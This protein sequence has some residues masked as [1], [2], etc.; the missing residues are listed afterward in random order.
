[1]PLLTPGVLGVFS[2]KFPK[3]PTPPR[4]NAEDADF[5]PAAAV[6]EGKAMFDV[7]MLWSSNGF[8]A[9]ALC[10]DEGI[11]A[12]DGPKILDEG[13]SLVW[14]DAEAVELFDID[15]ESLVELVS[16]ASVRGSHKI[17]RRGRSLT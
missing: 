11:L 14:F 1:M 5:V 8:L 3:T 10:D 12:E 7:L 13:G 17:Q 6:G 15:K 9:R 2:P 4:W 16:P